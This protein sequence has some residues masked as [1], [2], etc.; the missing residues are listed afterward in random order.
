[1]TSFG[2]WPTIFKTTHASDNKFSLLDNI[3][4]NNM[5]CLF[6]SGII[7]DD[8]SDHFPVFVSCAL[9][10]PP[11]KPGSRTVFDK[12]K[13]D[14]LSAHLMEHLQH[15]TEIDDPE[16][17]CNA[18]IE[19]YKTGILKFSVKVKQ[20]RKSTALKPWISPAILTSINQRHKL[21]LEKNRN[22]TEQNKR[23]YSAYRNKLNDIL[24]VAKRKI[25]QN[26]L[27][28]NR[29]NSKKLWQLLNETLRG[30]TSQKTNPDT[31]INDDGHETSNKEDIAQSFNHF[32]ISI[33][34]K[35]QQKIASCVENPLDY[36]PTK[37]EHIL[38]SMLH[39]NRT[40][41][42]EIIKQMKNVGAGIDTIN[43]SIFKNPY[44]AIVSELVH[45]VNL[46]L[47]H[48]RYISLCYETRC[49]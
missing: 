40:E 18:L 37:S 38:N 2:Y 49:C 5:D 27:E 34:E 31:F 20:S 9:E 21:F 7:Y 4:C 8:S 17:A 41:V 36:V 44:P 6:Q 23:M 35:L 47:T 45:L 48:G 25:V 46:C 39:T 19:A 32:F 42:V 43:A 26:Q 3:F 11:R 16:L 29:T 15:F 33:G 10:L 30:N 14:E 12:N 24:C 28:V 13:F 22:P 1:M